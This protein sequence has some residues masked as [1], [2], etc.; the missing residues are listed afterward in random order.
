MSA[1][2]W[3]DSSV[4]SGRPS[5]S[6]RPEGVVSAALVAVRLGSGHSVA[7]AADAQRLQRAV[8]NRATGRL[9]QRRLKFSG[10]WEEF[11]DTVKPYVDMTLTYREGFVSYARVG[12]NPRS[13]A[14][15]AL[16]VKVIDD[17]EHTAS[18]DFRAGANVQVGSFPEQGPA[19]NRP[20]V[21]HP[22]HIAAIERGAPGHG[23]A[24]IAHELY[25]N[26]E[27]VRH[28]RNQPALDPRAVY[29]H[30]HAHGGVVEEGKVAKDLAGSGLRRG[31]RMETVGGK[32]A[33]EPQR[34]T[35]V[36]DFETYFLRYAITHPGHGAAW[37]VEDV[38][39]VKRAEVKQLAV[40]RGD[41]ADAIAAVAGLLR[42]HRFSFARVDGPE[43]AAGEFVAAFRQKHTGLEDAIWA[44]GST[45]ATGDVVVIIDEPGDVRPKPARTPAPAAV[46][47]PPATAT[48]PPVEDPYALF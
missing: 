18:I 29:E 5:R 27:G 46:A 11:Y 37:T 39:T 34:I 6:S 1:H 22:L 43:L 41:K 12:S 10:D 17:S 3:A 8:G 32:K 4:R 20:Q 30:A 47:S 9:L 44:S 15:H 2:A 7:T 35:Q 33:G 21:I 38:E 40:P 42:E 16:L 25:E 14:L 48:E 45:S 31:D 24:K 19:P 13:P 36:Q 23:I 26:Y 28:A